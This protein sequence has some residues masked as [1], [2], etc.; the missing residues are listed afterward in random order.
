[1][2]FQFGAYVLDIDVEQ[3]RRFYKAAR[4]LT[5]GCSCSHCRNFEKAA[6][7]L[8]GD[9]KGFFDSLG[10][11]IKKPAEVYANVTNSDGTV[12]YGGFYHLCGKLLSGESAWITASNDGKATVSYW[13]SSMSYAVSDNFC[14]SFQQDCSL[15]EKGFPTPVIQMEIEANIPWVLDEPN[16]L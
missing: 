1:M 10:I 12:S 15:L 2:K 6:D 13:D 9:I 5:V 8:P 3:N 4:N 11:D 16:D 14:V 7:T